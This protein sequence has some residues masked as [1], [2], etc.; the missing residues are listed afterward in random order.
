MLMFILAFIT[1]DRVVWLRS[2]GFEAAFV[3]EYETSNK[4]LLRGKRKV[5]FVFRSPEV[6]VEERFRKMFATRL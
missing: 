3:G 4:E 2:T 1:K 6:L 5:D